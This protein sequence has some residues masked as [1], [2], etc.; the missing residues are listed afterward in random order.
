MSTLREASWDKFYAAQYDPS[1]E[2]ERAL[3][4]ALRQLGSTAS[5]EHRVSLM[6]AV[7]YVQGGKNSFRW[8][9][10]TRRQF[11][12]ACTRVTNPASKLRAAASELSHLISVTPALDRSV[13]EVVALDLETLSDALERVIPTIVE[14]QR[15]QLNSPGRFATDLPAHRTEFIEICTS[16]WMACGNAVKATADGKF[17]KFLSAMYVAA[18]Q[19]EPEST[20]WYMRIAKAYEQSHGK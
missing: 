7:A 17:D 16:V 6:A 12:L 4:E 18:R 3:A 2:E 15:Q 5:Q 20:S 19:E 13:V 8:P 9:Q 11:A 10:V 1:E 14:L